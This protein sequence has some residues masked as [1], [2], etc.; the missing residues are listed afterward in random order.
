MY[1]FHFILF[2]LF[3]NCVLMDKNRF[4]RLIIN[5]VFFFFLSGNKIPYQHVGIRM[6]TSSDFLNKWL[7]VFVYEENLVESGQCQ[8][9]IIIQYLDRLVPTVTCGEP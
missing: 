3:G 9:F 1:I 6:V 4:D 7:E 5:F 2:Y 8:L